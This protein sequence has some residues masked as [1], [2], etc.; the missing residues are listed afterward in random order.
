MDVKNKGYSKRGLILLC[1][2]VYFT[3]YFS[4]KSFAAATAGMLQAGVIEKDIAGLIGTVMF[5]MY[6]VGQIVS[7]VLGDMLPPKT[8]IL[9]GLGTTGVCNALMSVAPPVAMI[10]IWALNGLAQAM[11]WPPIV[12]L[13]SEYL[14]H[15]QYVR[16]N[17][18]VTAAAHVATILLY[19]YVPV[20]LQFFSWETVFIS[21]GV[22]AV[23]MFAVFFVGLNIC[24]PEQASVGRR[25]EKVGSSVGDGEQRGLFSVMREAGIIPVFFAIIAMGFLR[26]GIESW[27]PTLYAE[28]FKRDASEATLVSVVLPIFAIAC[29]TLITAL[30]K[31][32]LKNE[33]FGAGVMFIIAMVLCVPLILLIN[34]ATGVISIICLVLAAL[35]CGVMHSCNFLLISCLPGRFARFGR[36]AGASGLCN[37][38]TYIG[39]AI[40]SYGIAL[41]SAARGWQFTVGSWIAVAA[42]G[43]LCTA[44]SYRK[45]TKF[46][47]DDLK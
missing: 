17:L 16:A 8:L 28:A 35:V 30:H 29:V 4:R 9:L 42:I 37:A 44:L 25:A 5:I 45:Y 20:C 15:E 27:L 38:C 21:A 13:L 46:F 39:A 6:G 34:Q 47:A 19:L 1:S 14:D 24:L 3:S 22:L 33:A 31:R 12:K 43:L 10:P 36:S 11:M 18:L 32:L 40:S 2:I 7:G 26:D 23:V 41:L